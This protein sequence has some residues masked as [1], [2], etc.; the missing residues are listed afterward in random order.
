MA[1]IKFDG[2]GENPNLFNNYKL[3]YGRL[4]ST[5]KRLKEN[6]ETMKQYNNII[7]DKIKACVR[8]F[9]SDFYFFTK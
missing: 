1:D 6:P 3:S 9:L 8:Y 5:V 4:T 2:R 7:E